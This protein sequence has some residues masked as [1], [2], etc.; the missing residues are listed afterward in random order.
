M[1]MI[2]VKDE[3]RILWHPR[4]DQMT[5][6]RMLRFSKLAAE[7]SRRS[8]G[9]YQALH[10]WSIN[11]PEEFWGL[12]WEFL[13]LKYSES[14]DTAYEQA[15]P[16]WQSRF[17]VG[18]KLNFAENLLR[19]RGERSLVIFRDELGNRSEWSANELWNQVAGLADAL[20]TA[21]VVAGDRVA[22][23][24]PN[25]P[26]AL[27]SMLAAA[28]IGA[29]WSSCSPDFGKSGVLDRFGQIEPKV[30]I[31]C[32]R[33]HY[34][35]RTFDLLPRI[36]EVVE[37]LPS[38]ERTLVFPYLDEP[39]DLSGIPD[40][41]TFDE[42]RSPAKDIKFEQLPFDHPL[43]I[44]FTSGTTGVPKCIVHRA[45]GALVQIAKEH[46]LHCD[47]GNDDRLFFFT[48]CGWMMWNWLVTGLASESTLVLYDGS[49]FYPGPGSLWQ[50]A[51]EE[52]VTVFG[53]SAKYL[54]ALEKQEFAPGNHFDLSSLRLLLSTGSVLAPESYDYV[55]EKIKS[56]LLLVSMTGGTD[57]LSCFALGSPTLP[58]YRGELQ[59]PGLG[60][61]VSVFNEAGESV[62]GQSGELVCRQAFPTVPVGFWK[63]E[64]HR[65]FRAAYFERFPGVWH[66]GDLAEVT[67]N[68]GLIMQGRSDAVLNPG[69]VR[70]GT[71]EIYRQVERLDEVIESICIGQDWDKDVR[72]VLFVVLAEGVSLDENLID[73]IRFM[74]RTNASPRHMPAKI[75]AVP[76]VPRTR[77]GKLAE[78]A[79]RETV[80]GRP[81]ANTEALANSECL[82]Y[83]ADR[84]EL[85]Y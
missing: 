12:L 33:Y 74:I 27:A 64:D 16:M 25:H 34:N 85:R 14:W 11:C 15:T 30:L 73:R 83:F 61:A 39:L 52:Q 67:E 79:V 40:G 17:F 44:L 13:D 57:L 46:R 28:S 48:T 80:H 77:T 72:V 19:L 71:A 70:I 76:D 20:R 41:I 58:L 43:F 47:L 9:N 68:G 7:R 53:I 51:Q 10:D 81:V 55:Y 60:M 36:A 75:V 63:D 26:L 66:H 56:D 54:S 5:N 59:C 24:V 32:G 23:L 45:G 42:F 38:L 37:E 6:T 84:P 2:H 1:A 31:A 29:V 65:R 35:G 62:V 49:P 8:I 21:G 22:A 18:S 78:I 69:G 50:L 82:R 4:P 3:H